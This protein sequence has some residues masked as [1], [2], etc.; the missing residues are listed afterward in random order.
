M[1][2]R[3]ARPHPEHRQHPQPLDRVSSGRSGASTPAR[4]SSWCAGGGHNTLN[5]GTEGADFVAFFYNYGVNT[6]ILRNRLRRDGYERR[7]RRRAT[8]RC[9]PSRSCARTPRSGRSIRRRSA[10]W[11]SPPAP[12][13]PPPA[14]LIFATFDKTA[15][16]PD[17]S[18]R[19]ASAR[20]RISSGSSTPAPRRSRAA[21]TPDRSRATRRRRS[22][23]LRRLGR[24]RARDLGQRVLRRDAQR[25]CRTSR[26]TST[27]TACTRR[28]EGSRG[29]FRSAPGISGS[30]TGSATSVSSRSPASR[31][32]PHGTSPA[33]ASQPPLP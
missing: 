31:R 16:R 14:A 15:T 11:A 26:C 6:V 27:A 21:R 22:S 1:A 10:S 33:F 29:A 13:W 30:S 32:R 12:S 18:A 23:P 3:R 7:D 17:Q 8:T 25:A 24:P 2:T 28:I 9:R 20:V 5:V 4:R 19:R